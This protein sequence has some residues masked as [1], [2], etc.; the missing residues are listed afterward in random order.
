[1]TYVPSTAFSTLSQAIN[2]TLMWYNEKSSTRKLVDRIFVDPP[3]HYG[4]NS[5]HSTHSFTL[6]DCC[7]RTLATS[8][9]S[10]DSLS[11]GNCLRV[12]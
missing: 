12:D 9:T 1:M 5:M 8:A 2:V 10:L 11:G 4:S 6:V 7:R 3:I